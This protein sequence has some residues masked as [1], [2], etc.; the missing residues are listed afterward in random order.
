MLDTWCL[1][2]ALHTGHSE[3]LEGLHRVNP[4]LGTA[5]RMLWVSMPA[6][7][8]AAGGEQGGVG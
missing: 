3:S 4:D 6:T 7:V 1:G 5:V 2:S 8:E